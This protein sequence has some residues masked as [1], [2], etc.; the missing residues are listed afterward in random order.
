MN[1]PTSGFVYTSPSRLDAP[2]PKMDVPYL[3]LDSDL[4]ASLEIFYS[5]LKICFLSRLQLLRNHL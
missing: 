3:N 1:V 4:L 5:W 2:D